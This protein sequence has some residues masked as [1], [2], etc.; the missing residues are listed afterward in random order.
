MCI[1]YSSLTHNS[2]LEAFSI[3]VLTGDTYQFIKR[4]FASY[5]IDGYIGCFFE[6]VFIQRLSKHRLKWSVDST[7]Q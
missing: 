5:K 3:G 6:N 4:N 7:V 1:V 2:T